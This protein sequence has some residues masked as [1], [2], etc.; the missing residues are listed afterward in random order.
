MRTNRKALLASTVIAGLIGATPVLAQSQTNQ[1][2][3]EDTSATTVADVVVT[4]SRIRRNEFTS[5][6]PVQIITSE[7]AALE[8]TVDTSEILQSSTAASTAT[9]INNFFTGYVTT[10]GAGVNTISLRGLGANRTLVLVNGRRAGPAGISGTVGPTDLNTIPSSQIERVEILTDGASSIYG[11]DAVAGVINIITKTNQDGGSFQAFA[12]VPFESGGEEFRLNAS[13]GWSGDRGYLTVGADYYE[14]KALLFGDRDMF[15]CPQ[16]RVYYDEAL[17]IRADIIDPATGDYKC[18]SS[19]NGIVRANRVI[20]GA[21]RS[22]DFQPDASAIAGG[23]FL[24]CNEDGWRFAG[25]GTNTPCAT[26][27]QPTADR[28]ALQALYPSHSD[29]YDSRT[30]VSPVTRTSLSAFAG[31]DLTANTEIFGEFLFNRRE[32]SQHSWRQLFPNVFIGAPNYPFEALTAL[33]L[34]NDYAMPVA[35]MNMDNEQ[36]VDYTRVVAGIRGRL[37]IG[38]GWDWELA[39]QFSRSDAKYGNNFFYADRVYATSGYHQ[40]RIEN[41]VTVIPAAFASGANRTEFWNTGC[42]SAW[43]TTATACP[44]GGVNWFSPDYIVNGQLSQA[45]ADFLIGWEEGSTRYDHAYIEGVISGELFDLPA[46][47]LGMALGFQIRKEEIDDQPGEQ[48]QNSNSWGLTS[49]GRTKGEDT[50]KEAFLEMEV[51]LIRDVMLIDSLTLNV[52]GRY[53]DYDSYGEN[54]TYKV[55]ANW[56]ITPEYR[57]RASYGTAFRAPALYE[58]YLANQ[59]SYA[60]QTAVDPCINWGE[61]TD[62]A[63]RTNCA[64]AGIPEDYSAAGSSSAMVIAGG[65]RGVLE[66]ETADTLSAGFIWTPAFT[67][68]SV[69]LDYYKV[70]IEDQ[71]AR[72]GS[73]NILR[74]CYGAGGYQDTSLCGLFDRAPA[75]A[76]NQY[77][78]TQIRD[79]YINIAEQMS[80][81]LDLNV[82]YRK[83][84]AAGDLTLTARA[85]YILD[86]TYQLRSASQPSDQLDYIGYPDWTANLGARWDRGDWTVY[87]NVDLIPETTN[88]RS[89]NQVSYYG[90]TLYLDTTAEAV[91]Y[92]SLSV[93]KRMDKW[94][95]QVGV[96]NLFN[97]NAPW[98]SY[99]GGSRG[100]GNVPLTSQYDYV[101]RRA[102]VTVTRN[103]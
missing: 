80:E 59:T 89:A 70:T 83:E 17:K 76:T 40:G 66:A 37:D 81:G 46:G 3:Q 38:R 34:T 54:S 71:V 58:L 36:Q 84:F 33:G 50:V 67:D 91:Q 100:A 44:S 82:R 93:R 79:S 51:P 55:G 68:L 15:A 22:F 95:L 24:G 14:R 12:S 69:A 75:G 65:G 19:L 42:V 32:S 98:T 52:S 64:A 49:A 48:A 9:Q 72:F 25:G 13:H 88:I 26:N 96:N 28:R 5:S 94:T 18:S 60:G 4:G 31:Y 57:I 21:Y 43:L 7:Q 11:S 61:S 99:S 20:G 10:G 2:E 56:A 97:E 53:S 6:Q 45:E 92:H 90:E 16:D 62:A 73:A 78:V 85:S 29:R 27:T 35:H 41:G 103:W 30:A 63:I 101:G 39:G 86:W 23:G 102:F 1:N 74:G 8:G 47:P 77:Q 87:W